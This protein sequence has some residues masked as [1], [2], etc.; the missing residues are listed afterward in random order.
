[1][2][3]TKY[4]EFFINTKTAVSGFLRL[5]QFLVIHAFIHAGNYF[6]CIDTEKVYFKDTR[7]NIVN[8]GLRAR[9]RNI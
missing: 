8:D 9:N 1:M 5:V 4:P 6:K 2:G 3:R 7:L